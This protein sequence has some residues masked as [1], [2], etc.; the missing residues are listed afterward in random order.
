[1]AVDQE[2]VLGNFQQLLS[3]IDTLVLATVDSDGTPNA[4][5]VPYL[6]CEGSFYILTSGLSEHTQHLLSEKDI[7]VLV[8]RDEQDTRNI[9][10]RERISMRCA[11]AQVT[12]NQEEI[13]DGME[14]QLGKT[15]GLLRTLPDFTLFQLIPKSVRYV[16]GFGKAYTVSLDKHSATLI[17]GA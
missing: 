6:H 9:F 12:E 2:V 11:V 16:A 5:V 8:L 7:G 13:L 17:T 15:V 14:A 1:M 4:S 3:D 10:A